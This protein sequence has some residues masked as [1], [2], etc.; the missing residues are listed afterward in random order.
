M[1]LLVGI[2]AALFTTLPHWL[3]GNASVPWLELGVMFAVI[4]IVGLLA[5]LFASR[6]IFKMPLLE[7]LRA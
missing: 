4:A 6:Q 3:V 7:S 1:G 5:G 2:G